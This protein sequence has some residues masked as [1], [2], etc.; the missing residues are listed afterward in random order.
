MNREGAETYMRLLGEARM[1]GW[2]AAARARRPRRPRGGRRPPADLGLAQQP[3]VGFRALAVH[4]PSVRYFRDG[5]HGQHGPDAMS[6]PLTCTSMVSCGAVSG[7]TSRSLNPVSPV[8]RPG[9]L[10]PPEQRSVPR[11]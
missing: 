4:A 5:A 8:E 11:P 7:G 2:L 10:H 6:A 1:R 3:Q 9:S